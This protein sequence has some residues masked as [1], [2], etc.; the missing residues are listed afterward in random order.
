MSATPDSTLSTSA[1]SPAPPRQL[2]LAIESSCDETAAAVVRS[3][4][5]VLSSI[6]ASQHEL[7]H[8]WG[9]VVPEIA[10]RAHVR[11]LL[12]VLQSALDEAG[13]QLR[14]LAAIAVSAAKPPRSRAEASR[15]FITL[16]NFIAVFLLG[17][18]GAS[19]KTRRMLV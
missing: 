7:H 16:E 14:D 1:H 11:R 8:E 18:I 15:P 6:I 17:T 19:R 9:G 4:G 13:C 3:D 5:Q 2:L 12:P 10:S